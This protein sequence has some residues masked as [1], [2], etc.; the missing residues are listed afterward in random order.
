[1]AQQLKNPDEILAFLRDNTDLNANQASERLSLAG[2]SAAPITVRKLREKYEIPCTYSRAFEL[3]AF[4]P[5]LLAELD[6][7]LAKVYGKHIKGAMAK[8][9]SK[10]KVQR[11]NLY[12]Y[13]QR[14]TNPPKSAIK[15]NPEV[16]ANNGIKWQYKTREYRKGNAIVRVYLRQGEQV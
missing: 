1:M 10:Y 12:A 4:T 9:A 14:K 16:Y 7:D 8:L 13:Q 11:H 15:E 5:E 6:A 2:L 3:D